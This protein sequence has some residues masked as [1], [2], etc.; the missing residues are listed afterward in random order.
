[1]VSRELPLEETNMTG[2]RCLHGSVRFRKYDWAYVGQGKSGAQGIYG[3]SSDV[4][5]KWLDL[6]FP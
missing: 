3:I 4:F 6:S 2:H 5:H 1:M